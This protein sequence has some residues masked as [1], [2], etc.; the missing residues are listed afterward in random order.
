MTAV[1]AVTET[2]IDFF[3]PVFAWPLQPDA[4]PLMG[5]CEQAAA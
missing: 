1:M 5:T 2:E 4:K 3:V